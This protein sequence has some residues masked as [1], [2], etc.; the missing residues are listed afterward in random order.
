MPENVR[1][2]QVPQ[3]DV[4]SG[5]IQ[6]PYESHIGAVLGGQ[7]RLGPMIKEDEAGGERVY[8]I[9]ALLAPD[10]V[11]EARSYSLQGLPEKL[12]TARKRHMKRLRARSVCEID[13]AG[14][15]FLIY[16]RN[17][18]SGR[19]EKR[20][21]TKPELSWPLSHKGKVDQ[22][23]TTPLEG[24]GQLQ[25]SEKSIARANSEAA[26]INQETTT[27]KDPLASN[28]SVSESQEASPR[29]S[30]QGKRPR[31]RK[32][33]RKMSLV[34]SGQQSLLASTAEDGNE[35]TVQLPL[36]D[37]HPYS[38]GGTD[39]KQRHLAARDRHQT[40][41]QLLEKNANINWAHHGIRVPLSWAAAEGYETVVRLLLE[42][43]AN[44]ESKNGRSP[45]PLSLAT[46]RGH[47]TIV[48]LLL[49]K[50]ADVEPKNSRNQTPL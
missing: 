19:R 31:R 34:L 8:T 20:L 26:E 40:I 15:K 18:T 46:E 44:V 9:T 28:L 43:G 7:F 33:K 38:N 3:A 10:E 45:T 25:D 24:S 21:M 42:K 30:R 32:R 29:L 39:Q 41:I 17:V 22:Y 48:R 16:R 14:K 27:P 6:I 1:R 49:E 35:E 12:Q 2:R 47:E 11:Y 36:E 13:Q 50:G 37:T 23:T 5:I 4:S